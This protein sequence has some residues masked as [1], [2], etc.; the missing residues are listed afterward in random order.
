MLKKAKLGLRHPFLGSSSLTVSQ[1]TMLKT[2]THFNNRGK[3]SFVY[4]GCFLVTTPSSVGKLSL[5]D[6]NF[7]Y[8]TP[9]WATL[10]DSAAVFFSQN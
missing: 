7:H 10:A 4:C 9:F 6:N 5:K 2:I 1:T 3:T 8:K